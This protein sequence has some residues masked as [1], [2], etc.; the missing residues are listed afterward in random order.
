MIKILS[1][2]PY[3]FLPAV[4][5][6]QKGIALFY[7]YLSKHCS[8]TCISVKNNKLDLERD[9]QLLPLLSNSPL[10]YINIFYFFQLQKLIK[11]EQFT[12]LVLEH[13]YY[14]WLGFLLKKVMGIKLIVH[15]H[16]IEATRF[17]SL[18]KWWWKIL[19]IYEKWI[20]QKS[21]LVF[22][23]TE[24]DKEFAIKNYK[25]K[26]STCEVITYG[27]EQNIAPLDKER[28][29]AKAILNQYHNILPDTTIILF[30]GAF[31]Y[32]PNREALFTIIHK[33]NP[34][35]QQIKKFKYRIIICGK[36]IPEEIKDQPGISIAGFVDDVSLYFKGTDVFLNPIVDGG[37]IKTKLVE[38]LS[39]GCNAVSVKSGATGVEP[40][41][42]SGKLT[43][44]NNN[45]W[46]AFTNNV[47]SLSTLRKSTPNEFYGYFYWGSIAQKAINTIEKY[48]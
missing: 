13:P 36:N 3:Q 28:A 2:V 47:L 16:N 24:D 34:A 35:L 31:G 39:Y 30:N 22:F 1:I 33:I 14:G 12:H 29:E 17:K 8:I 48:A 6:G 10:R 37:G 4:T 23:I 15:S 20:Y 38:A 11:K 9:Y 40:Q 26:R 19:R 21:D 46:I 43:I 18:N 42:C 7:K 41:L 44:V 45:D 25:T 32:L 27:T 5:G